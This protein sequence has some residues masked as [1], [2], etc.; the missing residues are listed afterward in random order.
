MTGTS[1]ID[2]KVTKTSMW[3]ACL[4]CEGEGE[5]GKK[6]TE[7]VREDVVIEMICI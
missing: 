5:W 3:E 2:N 7:E 4:R 1:N 6:W